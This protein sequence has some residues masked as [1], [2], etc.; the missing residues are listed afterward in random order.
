MQAVLSRIAESRPS[1]ASIWNALKGLPGGTR[2]FSKLIGSMAPYTATIDCHVTA[3]DL[4]H[5]EVRLRDRRA[6]RNHLDCVHAIALMNLG[7]VSTGLA[8]LYAIDGRGRGIISKLSMEYYKKARG[9]ITATCDATVPSTRGD[10][11]AK[12]EAFLRDGSGQVVAKAFATWK[13]TLD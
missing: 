11:H 6:V 7:E 8:M 13:L 1:V 5:S 10:H 12:V 9:T 4:G 2:M 3:L